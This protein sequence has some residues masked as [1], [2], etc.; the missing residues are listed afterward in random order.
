M[1]LV[2]LEIENFV[3]LFSFLLFLLNR[4][5]R[6][7]NLSGISCCTYSIHVSQFTDIDFKFLFAITSSNLSLA[8][9]AFVIFTELKINESTKGLVEWSKKRFSRAFVPWS[10]RKYALCVNRN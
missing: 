5:G 7:A 4:N 6:I 10:V 9:L 2:A 1:C 8:S 3:Y